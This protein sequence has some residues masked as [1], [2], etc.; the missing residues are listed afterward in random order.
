M[1]ENELQIYG[2]VGGCGSG[3]E[4]KVFE[5]D[6][7]KFGSDEGL[8]IVPNTDVNVAGSIVKTKL[9]PRQLPT[10]GLVIVY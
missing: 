1:H 2:I 4:G 3:G 7:E 5:G 8:S 10:H 9:T 6:V